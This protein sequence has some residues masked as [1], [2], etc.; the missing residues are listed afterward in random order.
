MSR[1]IVLGLP[2]STDEGV[3][4]LAEFDGSPEEAEQAANTFE[5]DLWKVRRREVFRCSDRS[6]FIRV[7]GRVNTRSFLIQLA[8]LVHDSATRPTT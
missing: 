3:R 4:T 1:W 2:V 8:E 7:H 6:H 5:C